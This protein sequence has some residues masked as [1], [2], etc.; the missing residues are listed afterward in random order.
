METKQILPQ[1]I[2]GAISEKDKRE[3]MIEINK[4]L[5]DNETKK[6]RKLLAKV[7]GHSEAFK[8]IHSRIEAQIKLNGSAIH[9]EK[10]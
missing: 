2:N 4:R 7:M 1:K 5:Q 6:A 10:V 9:D 8:I 3:K